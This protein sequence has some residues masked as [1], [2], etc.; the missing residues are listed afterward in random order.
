MADDVAPID[1]NTA[2]RVA[3][4]ALQA[5]ASPEAAVADAE[6]VLAGE[7][8]FASLASLSL[9]GGY[10]CDKW[11]TN[12]EARLALHEAVTARDVQWEM[13]PY[14]RRLSI[15]APFPPWLLELAA[16]LAP[17]FDGTPPDQCD[18]YALEPDHQA[19]ESCMDEPE[20]VY[21][22]VSACVSLLGCGRLLCSVAHGS[23]SEL[24]VP[25]GAC[26]L[27]RDEAHTCLSLR[28]VAAER[29]LALVFRRRL[30]QPMVAETHSSEDS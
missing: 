1:F 16:R 13:M 28:R 3:R 9:E 6:L 15:N 20:G 26:L 19:P 22:P 25:A 7:R 4:S 10:L 14:G 2:I 5:G 23:S 30:D 27:L 21:A 12:S 18:L 11:L 17:A 8:P 29:H 24:E